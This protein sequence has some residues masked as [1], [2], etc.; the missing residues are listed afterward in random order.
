MRI[1]KSENE[2]EALKY[3]NYYRGKALINAAKAAS[4]TDNIENAGEKGAFE[5]T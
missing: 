3:L 4:A 5:N 1:A 2:A